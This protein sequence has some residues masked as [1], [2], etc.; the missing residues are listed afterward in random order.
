MYED[1]KDMEQTINS[2]KT[3]N[4]VN[5]WQRTVAFFMNPRNLFILGLLIIVALTFSEVVRGRQRNFMIFVESTKLFW[6][7]IAPYGENWLQIAPKLDFF[8][9]GPL[10][11][12]LFTPF[13]YLPSWLAPFAWNVFN[14]SLWFTAI[15]TLP[16][17]FTTDEKCKSFMFTF[18]ILSCTQLSFQY[19]VAVGYLFLFTYSLLEK[20]KGFWAILL[21]MISGFTKIYGIFQLV[22]LLFYPR[23]SRNIGFVLLIAVAFLIA[24]AINMPFSELP[25]YYGKWI[26]AL[27]DHKDT[28]TWMN[29]FYLKPLNL[30]PYQM[31]IQ[32]GA[33]MALITGALIHRRK[34]CTPFF[35]ISFM[36]ALMGYVILFS[37]SSEG[38][39]YVISLI[40]YQMW[41]WTMYRTQSLYRV[42]KILFWAIF[43]I[44]VVMPVDVL[45]PPAVMRIFYGLQLNLW[46]LLAM[47][48]RICYTAFISSPLQ[49]QRQ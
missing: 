39:T 10:F 13:A 15:F 34:W 8:L 28:R 49:L 33:L 23:L 9:Y 18:L 11:N 7:H 24:P 30:L 14:F 2:V 5:M 29:I 4:R 17:Q 3:G 48:L 41:Y 1:R 45:C 22:M 27:T 16:K 21:I 35:R 26:S 44:V 19:N 47:W 36:A 40:G 46:L 31:Y 43:L 32:I 12:I 6:Q 25:S 37:N 38:H 20:N 42:D